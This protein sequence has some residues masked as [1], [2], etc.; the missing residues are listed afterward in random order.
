MPEIRSRN[1][2]KLIART[3]FFVVRAMLIARQ[4][5]AKHILAEADARNNRSVAAS[6]AVNRLCFP[7]DPCKFDISESSSEAGTCGRTR[8]RIEGVQRSTTEY[9]RVRLRKEDSMCAV[10]TVRLL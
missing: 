5:I 10:V 7:Y 3:A 6:S 9:N 1:N 2:I 4:R 8:M